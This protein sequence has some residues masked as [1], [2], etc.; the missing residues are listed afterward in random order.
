MNIRACMS[1]L[2]LALPFAPFAGAGQEAPVDRLIRLLS[3]SWTV[4]MKMPEIQQ[5]VAKLGDA[6]D[7]A[8]GAVMRQFNRKDQS[9]VFRHRA[10]RV[11]EAI[12]SPK[13]QQA[14]LHIALGRTAVRTQRSLKTGAS[15]A[16]LAAARDKAEARKLLTSD[17]D[18]V[19]N[20]A[21]LAL[22]GQP[23]DT[24]MLARLKELLQ[25][26]NMH[27]AICW[28]A[29][30]VLA[31][32]P[33]AELAAQKVAAILGAIPNV[34]D[35]PKANEIYWPGNFTYAEATYRRYTR[36]LAKMRGADGPLKDATARARGPTRG[37]VIL[38][39]A[40]R[41]DR[42]VREDIRKLSQD[43]DAGRMRAW[44]ARALGL[45]GEPEDLKLLEKIA[46]SDPLER[47]LGG[48]L[49]PLNQQKFFPVRGAAGEA[50]KILRARAASP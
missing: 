43:P 16:Y 39:R 4:K 18:G 30:S 1:I 25:A 19:V 46:E 38:A 28:S 49:A 48:C 50:I 34:K 2:L 45:I 13:A 36:S 47:E 8:V 22:K 23:I 17:V 15:R 10:I 35:M 26:K 37:C 6:K 32:D 44:A 27:M 3:Q 9:F 41:G 5:E 24:T 33:R 11:F 42:A 21:L 7:A 29:A 14:L 20:N 40:E 12:G 31:E